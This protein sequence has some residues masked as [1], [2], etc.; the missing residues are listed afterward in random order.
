MEK[1]WLSPAFIIFKSSFFRHASKFPVVL[2]N[3]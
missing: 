2:I 1:G 3:Y